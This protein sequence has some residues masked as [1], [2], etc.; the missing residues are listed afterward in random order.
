MKHSEIR[1]IVLDE[2]FSKAKD[3]CDIGYADEL[4]CLACCYGVF[5]MMRF[6][7]DNGADIDFD[8][9]RPL[10]YAA[11]GEF[12]ILKYLLDRGAR[13]SDAVMYEAVGQED[14]EIIRC[15][16]ENGGVVD[17]G[18]IEHSIIEDNPEITEYIKSL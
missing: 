14:I 3:V 6:A 12:Q 18:V 5:G 2:D 10:S 8:D 11:R 4:L 1:S 7:L 16:I 17:L 9:C 13:I 15:L